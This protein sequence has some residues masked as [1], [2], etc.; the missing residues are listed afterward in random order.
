MTT[1]RKQGNTYLVWEDNHIW[2]TPVRI[3]TGNTSSTTG[4]DGNGYNYVYCRTAEGVAPVKPVNLTVEN[5]ESI[6][7]P[8][9]GISIEGTLSNRQYNVWYDHPLGVDDNYQYEWIAI[10]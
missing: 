8:T 4:N 10:A 6:T 3:G 2:S 1:A 7:D 5:I 9:Y